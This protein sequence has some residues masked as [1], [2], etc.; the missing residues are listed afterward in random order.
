GRFCAML[1][2]DMGAEVLRVVRPGTQ[3]DPHDVASRG[4]TTLP[5]DLRST[6]AMHDLLAL[7][8]RAD[9]LID[10]L[11]PG[12]LEGLGLA[13]DVCLDRRPQL[14][15]GRLSGWGQHGPLAHAGGHEINHIAISGALHAIGRSGDGPAPPPNPM[16][17]LGAGA[18]LLAFGVMAALHEARRSGR[19]QV[20]DAA[21]SDGAALLS[22][23]LY[24]A[25]SAGTWS[26]QR[27]ENLRDGGAPFYDS[28]ACA[29]GKHVAIGAIEPE[30]YALLL[31]RCGI[32][33]DPAF[34]RQMDATRWPMQ[35]LR[36]ADVFRTRTRDA[37]CA[38]LEGSGACFAPVLDADE[39][40]RHAH[41]LA[42][43]T[44]TTVDGVVQPAPAPR[45]S[46]TPA[47]L[48]GGVAGT[49]DCHALLMR[50]G[51]SQTV[52]ARWSEAHV[53]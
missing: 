36:L 52:A 42:R 38:L 25:R 15:V 34:D 48:P 35:K 32:A 20:V 13:P 28:Y 37:W 53:G 31:Q 45:L 16:G 51:V 9:V 10:G 1:F 7:I 30:C 27:G 47:A 14:V 26:N 39:A 6:D 22:A 33:D 21:T 19:G 43:G 50:W 11:G 46:R 2:A 3:P 17:E 29:D 23:T 44:F 5:L 49:P 8:E 18:V 24:G 12:V 40:P 4:R 41:N